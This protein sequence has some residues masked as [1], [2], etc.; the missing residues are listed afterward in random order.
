MCCSPFE[1]VF[2]LFFLFRTTSSPA[3]LHC[4]VSLLP[5]EVADQHPAGQG[6][7]APDELPEPP[8]RPSPNLMFTVG[9]VI[10]DMSS[11]CSCLTRGLSLLAHLS[12]SSLSVCLVFSPCICLYLT[13]LR[14]SYVCQYPAYGGPKQHCLLPSISLPR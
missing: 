7:S 9:L 6:R 5:K 13:S 3:H 8:D 14:F 2:L 12:V 10:P 1:H 11:S 4:T